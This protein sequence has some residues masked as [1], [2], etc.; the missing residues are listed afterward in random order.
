[1]SKEPKDW[2]EARL[3]CARLR[4]ER[5]IRWGFFG[6]C[7][8]VV[9][10]YINGIWSGFPPCCV[11]AYALENFRWYRTRRPHA[12]ARFL[13]CV[14]SQEDYDY[15]C[16]QSGYVQCEACFRARYHLPQRK[17]R[18]GGLSIGWLVDKKLRD[19]QRQAE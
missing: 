18:A 13:D 8:L 14:H 9:M 4:S 15:W 12:V 10:D 1:M 6:I 16:G 2:R 5:Y 7:L 3:R 17:L 19:A 11:W